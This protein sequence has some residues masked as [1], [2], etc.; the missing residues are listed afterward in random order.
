[1]RRTLVVSM[2]L[3]AVANAPAAAQAC[4]GLPSHAN[5]QMQVAGNASF[6]D[7]YNSFGGSFGYGQPAGLFAHAQI[8]TTSY[9][10]MDGSEIGL[11]DTALQVWAI[12]RWPLL[13]AAT[14][15]FR[16]HARRGYDLVRTKLARIN[17]FLQ[18]HLSGA[19]TVQIFNAEEKSLRQFAKINHEHRKANIDTIFYYAV[20]F[21]LV[22]FIGAVGI[23]LIIWYGGGRVVNDALTLGSLVAFLQYSQR[24]FRPISDMSEKFNTLQAAMASSERIFQL[25]D[26][27][28][29]VKNSL[30][31]QRAESRGRRAKSRRRTSAPPYLVARRAG[32]KLVSERTAVSKVLPRCPVSLLPP[33]RT[34]FVQRTLAA[35][36]RTGNYRPTSR[37]SLVAV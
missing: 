25:L 21:P 27:E 5:G 31:G 26:T 4:L 29:A 18:E 13:F 30:T 14:T 24:F 22:D 33:P 34:R 6:S 7:L 15:W 20:F 2:A 1:M 8:G 17:S 32:W 3:L 35:Q 23:A 37:G 12:V 36:S 11:G 9:D 16:G 10:G 19:Q 28:V